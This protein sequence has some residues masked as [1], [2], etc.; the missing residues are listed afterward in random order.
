MSDNG[1][2][3]VFKVANSWGSDFGEDGYYYITL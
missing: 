2:Q 1:E 3:G